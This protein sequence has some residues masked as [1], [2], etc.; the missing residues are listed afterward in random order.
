M[1]ECDQGECVENA[2]RKR[3]R[4][5]QR[6]GEKERARYKETIFMTG[7]PGRCLS[8]GSA[9]DQERSSGSC[10]PNQVLPTSRISPLHPALLVLIRLRLV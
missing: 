2:A 7:V 6:E 3:R 8:L 1:L 4:F 10:F 9:L 5:R